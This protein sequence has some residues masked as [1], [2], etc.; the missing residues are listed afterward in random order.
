MAKPSG[1]EVEIWTDGA[2][3]GNPGPGG[4]AAI[5]VARGAEKELVGG[6]ARTTNNRMELMG[7]IAGLEALKRPSRVRLSSDSQYV[8]RGMTEW[9]DGWRRK[10]WKKVMNRDLWERLAAAAAPHAVEW[11]WVRGHAGDAM[12]ERCDRLANAEAERW[13]AGGGA[14]SPAAPEP[15]P[16]GEP[17]LRAWCVTLQA[18][19][20]RRRLAVVVAADAAEAVELARARV[21]GAAKA[22]GEALEVDLSGPGV[23]ALWEGAPVE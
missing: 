11:T 8:T 14:A 3:L 2:C 23:S 20:G 21:P 1:V 19:V 7:A 18:G 10:G 17:A 4:W 5:L 12:N 16:D 9:I 15:E 6:E 22:H 13:K